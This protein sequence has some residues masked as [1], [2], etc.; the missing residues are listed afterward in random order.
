MKEQ[1]SIYAQ[2]YW[3][4]LALGAWVLCAILF[5]LIRLDAYGLEEQ[6]ARALL[7][8]W[9]VSDNIVN[10]IVIFGI[11]DFRALLFIPVGTYWAGSMLA[12][13]IFSLMIAFAAVTVLYRWATRMFDQDSALIAAAL[14]LI[15][16]LLIHELDGLGSGHYLLLGFG[17]LAWLDM[18]YRSKDGYFGGWYFSMILVTALMVT[19]HPMGMAA[20][21][22]LFLH[23]ILKPD[24]RKKSLHMI[25][26]LAISTTIALSMSHGWFNG[27]WFAN[28]ISI[29]ASSFNGA[30]YWVPE[31]PSIGLGLLFAIFSIVVLLAN[32][33]Q[34]KSNLLGLL[35]LCALA[36]GVLQADR[37]WALMLLAM[38]LFGAIPLLTRIND[39]F[40]GQGFI[41]K[42]GLVGLIAFI[43]CTNFMLQAKDHSIANQLHTLSPIDELIEKLANKAADKSAP[44]RAASEWPGRAMLA[45]KRDIYP[46]PPVIDE[47]EEFRKISKGLTHMMFDPFNEK[48]K[49]I[50]DHL[51]NMTGETETSVYLKAGVIVDIRDHNVEASNYRAPIK[52]S[53]KQNGSHKEDDE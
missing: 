42:R 40:K 21:F 8:N 11:P 5:D 48:N 31:N 18:K 49:S 26:G 7:L 20:P 10:P 2:K 16:P 4:F 43:V 35:L 39:R 12:A 29:L 41:A 51:A 45:T 44:F 36:L 53:E 23:W 33:Q 3:G 47:L 28:P 17:V 32:S 15:S 24:A 46:L 38:T 6:A 25:V 19:I 30:V 22:G 34:F 13:K 50:A 37:A 9:S 1:M 14:L 52:D 27:E